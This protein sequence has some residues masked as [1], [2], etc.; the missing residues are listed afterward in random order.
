MISLPDSREMQSE[1]RHGSYCRAFLVLGA[2]CIAK[3]FSLGFVRKVLALGDAVLRCL[4]NAHLQSI[5][6]AFSGRRALPRRRSP[7]FARYLG[8]N[9][10]LMAESK[11]R[12]QN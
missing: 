2:K 12:N 9:L 5:N 10:E 6:C 4:Q 1:G 7:T 8:S 11:G 3:A